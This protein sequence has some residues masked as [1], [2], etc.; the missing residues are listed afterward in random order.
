MNLSQK[1][2]I[3]SLVTFSLLGAASTLLAA[4]NPSGTGQPGAPSVSCG[5]GNAVLQPKG[6][7]T[8]GFAHAESVYAGSPGTPSLDR[9]A[10]SHAIAQYDIACYQ[11]T[12]NH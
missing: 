1:I 5:Q 6:F 3:A 4:A 8:T 10:S 7:T 11:M 12:Q 2:V 9:A